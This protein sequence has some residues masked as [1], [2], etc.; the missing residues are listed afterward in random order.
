M[1]NVKHVGFIVGGS[2]AFMQEEHATLEDAY[3]Q[4]FSNVLAMV[5]ECVGQNVPVM[6]F[7]LLPQEIEDH[8]QY[9]LVVD[10]LVRFVEELRN[11]P[12]IKERQVKVAVLGHWY[13]LPGRLVDAVKALMEETRD[14][15][16]FFLNLCLNYD[17][18][19]EIVDAAKLIGHQIKAGKLDP[20]VIGMDHIKEGIYTSALPPPDMIIKTGMSRKLSGFL[21]WDCA[22]ADIH[23]TGKPWQQFSRQ[24]FKDILTK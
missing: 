9:P 3:T 23:I 6:T 21:L 15:D 7:L 13:N 2:K 10:S 1:G 11:W 4:K 19:Q 16:G 22:N 20:D 18:R 8:K 5:E 17:G 12:L 14:Y 24:D